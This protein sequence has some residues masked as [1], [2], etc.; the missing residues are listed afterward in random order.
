M[1]RELE[2]SEHAIDRFFSRYRVEIS[3]EELL[4]IQFQM[5]YGIGDISYL[6]RIKSKDVECYHGVHRGIEFF[7]ICLIDSYLILT[8]FNLSC[9]KNKVL[10]KDKKKKF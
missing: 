10:V 7:A 1:S 6:G 9:L 2:Y 3:P 5:K 4:Y 8:F